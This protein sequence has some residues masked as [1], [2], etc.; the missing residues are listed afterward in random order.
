M[1]T[2]FTTLAIGDKSI[3]A[4]RTAYAMLS[5]LA[6]LPQGSNA[7]LTIVTDHPR[8]FAW[9]ADT[10]R[11]VEVDAATV[12]KWKGPANYF[13]RCEIGVLQHLATLGEANL[14]YLDSD[15]IVRRELSGFLAALTGGARFMHMRER[16]ID[17]SPRKGEQ[18]LWRQ[19]RGKTAAGITLQAPCT[20]WNAGVMA[21]PWA[22]RGLIDQVAELTDGLM[23]QGVTHWLVEQLAYGQVFQQTLGLQAAEPWMDHWWD[24]KPGY[25]A[26][27]AEFL[28]EARL[29][30]WTASEAAAQLHQHPIT[31]P[32]SVRRRWYH[33]LLRVE[34]RYRG[35]AA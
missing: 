34:P 28:L 11:I 33:R 31:L 23:A 22:E 27:I 30:G 6:K 8:R 17:R 15:I 10:I 20:M 26:L 13:F 1:L 24:N 25:D 18:E 5:V 32:L 21:V 4:V 12:E 9:L 35:P 16:D 14:V 2:R 7:E 29:Q 3:Y 19:V